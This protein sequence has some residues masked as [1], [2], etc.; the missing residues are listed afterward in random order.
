L[1]WL[2][3]YV[4]QRRAGSDRTL[5]KAKKTHEPFDAVIMDLTVPGG[6]GGIE[7]MAIL[8]QIEPQ[9]KAIVSS[10][11]AS[12]PVMSDYEKYGFSGF[13]AK[14]YKFDELNEVLN[15]VIDKEQLTLDLT[16]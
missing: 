6:L 3:S 9:I 13:V 8:R 12:D 10:G 4:G 14:P 15:K 2:P 1:L 5:K 7:T 11:Y 16:Y